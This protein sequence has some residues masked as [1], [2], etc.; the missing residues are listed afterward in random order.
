MLRP[1]AWP[2]RRELFVD[3]YGYAMELQQ[4]EVVLMDQ[5]QENLGEHKGMITP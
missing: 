3:K 1:Q 5:D 4:T 2:H